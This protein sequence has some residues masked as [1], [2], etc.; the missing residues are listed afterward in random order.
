[1]TNV[2]HG[3]CKYKPEYCEMLIEHMSQGYSF[4]SFGAII[5]VGRNT[6]YM[7]S[8]DIEEFAEAKEIA[9]MMA[10]KYFETALKSSSISEKIDDR[11]LRES[12]NPDKI[13]PETIKWF[14]KTRFHKDYSEKNVTVIEGGDKPVEISKKMDLSNLSLDELKALREIKAKINATE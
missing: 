12:F 1:M 5:R 8:R 11:H 13:N 14:M 9:E 7:W 6:L 2:N 3:L 4:A 10:L